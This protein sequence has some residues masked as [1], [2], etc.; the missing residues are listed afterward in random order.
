MILNEI[1]TTIKILKENII[2]KIYL[3]GKCFDNNVHLLPIC[4]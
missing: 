2:I 4:L 3:P 1:L